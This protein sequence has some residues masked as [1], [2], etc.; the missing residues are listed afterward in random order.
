MAKSTFAE[1][2]AGVTRVI[3]M[4]GWL[5]MLFNNRTAIL[6]L[7]PVTLRRRQWTTTPV[8]IRT[9]RSVKLS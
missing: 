3:A 8:S 4:A 9:F 1:G 5:G 7:L 6:H 2:L